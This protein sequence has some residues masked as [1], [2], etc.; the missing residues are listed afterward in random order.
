VIDALTDTRPRSRKPHP[1]SKGG[2]RR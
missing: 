2:V 1:F